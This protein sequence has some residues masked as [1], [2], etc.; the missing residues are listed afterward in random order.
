[1]V[2]PPSVP[3]VEELTW[4]LEDG[5]RIAGILLVW[6]LFA[7]VVGELIAMMSFTI[8]AQV[9]TLLLVAGTLNG[10][11]YAGY[12]VVD[13]WHWKAGREGV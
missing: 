10:L 4:Y 2:E 3:T 7:L 1:M 5:T 6:G 8:G 12:R 11:L 9:R 13:Y